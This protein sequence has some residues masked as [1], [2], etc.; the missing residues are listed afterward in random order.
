VIEFR[1]ARD[2]GRYHN[3]VDRMKG[4]IG[5]TDN[6]WFAFLLRSSKG[7][8]VK[9]ITQC[10]IQ[11]VTNRSLQS[12]ILGSGNLIMMLR[13]STNQFVHQWRM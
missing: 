2:W 12:G 4:F 1:D 7:E 9:A 6:D 13:T 5:V 10:D 8:E 11:E 3:P